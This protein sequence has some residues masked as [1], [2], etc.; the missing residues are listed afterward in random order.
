M[1]S[2]NPLVTFALFSYNQEKYIREAVESALAQT[3]SPLEIIISD[4]CSSDETFKIIE[5]VSAAYKGP[6]NIITNRNAINLGLGAHV[7]KCMEMAVGDW[8]VMA[9]GDDISTPERT[10]LLMKAAVETPNLGAISSNYDL[11]DDNNQPL[12][13]TYL[14]SSDPHIRSSDLDL[15]LLGSPKRLPSPLSGCVAAWHRSVFSVNNYLPDNCWCEDFFLSIRC[16]SLGFDLLRISPSLVKYRSHESNISGFRR[17]NKAEYAT[18]LE[19]L[20]ERT[21]ATCDLICNDLK[22]LKTSGITGIGDEITIRLIFT[23]QMLKKQSMLTSKIKRKEPVTFRQL[24]SFRNYYDKWSLV[25]TLVKVS[26][27]KIRG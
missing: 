19:T 2:S 27:N 13:K 11:I 23:I 22:N 26:L 15:Y 20:L 8:L 6:H 12:Q 5:E 14:T 3:Y 16:L 24:W 1:T 25:K 10:S 7:R 4:D 21:R 18:K 9:A 17:E